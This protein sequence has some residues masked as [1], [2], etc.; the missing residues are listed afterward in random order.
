[1]GNRD[2]KEEE[3][4]EEEASHAIAVPFSLILVGTA[5]EREKAVLLFKVT[6]F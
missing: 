4:E 5:K 1:M 2:S 6:F 3:E